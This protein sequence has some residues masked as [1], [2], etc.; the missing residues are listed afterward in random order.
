MTE[1]AILG[2]K[3]GPVA[4]STT[5]EGGIVDS[6]A[7]DSKDIREG[8]STIGE[9]GGSELD[10]ATAEPEVGV[11]GACSLAVDSLTDSSANNDSSSDTGRGI[12]DSSMTLGIVGTSDGE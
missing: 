10:S 4:D 1:L 7:V 6:D 9:G 11:E 2:N 8:A 3:D 12:S 5:G